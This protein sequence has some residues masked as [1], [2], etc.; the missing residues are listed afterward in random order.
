[1]TAG[2]SRTRRSDAVRALGGE[3]TAT[4][5]EQLRALG[6]GD[7]AIA[8]ILRVDRDALAGWFQLQDDL[9]GHDDLDGAAR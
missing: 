9:V 3:R 8:R 4:R 1:M 7:R 6:N 2:L 5:A